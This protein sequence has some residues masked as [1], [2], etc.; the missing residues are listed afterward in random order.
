MTNIS[1]VEHLK[2]TQFFTTLNSFKLV[3]HF[4]EKALFFPQSNHRLKMIRTQLLTSYFH[5]NIP[6]TFGISAYLP[7]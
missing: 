5:L 7:E 4:V 1:Q 6:D 2:Q 3:T